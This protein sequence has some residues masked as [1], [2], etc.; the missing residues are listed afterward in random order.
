[1][2]QDRDKP[3]QPRKPRTEDDLLEDGFTSEQRRAPELKATPPRGDSAPPDI[4]MYREI[5]GDRVG[6]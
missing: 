1:M 3:T 5:H 6:G 4:D 2:K